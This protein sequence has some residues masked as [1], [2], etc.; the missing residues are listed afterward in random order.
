MPGITIHIERLLEFYSPFRVLG[1][2]P[3]LNREVVVR[4][5]ERLEFV[6]DRERRRAGKRW[7]IGRVRFLVRRLDEG[8]TP[9]PIEIDNYCDHGHVYGP[10]VL[11]G[12]HRLIASIVVGKPTIKA[13]YSGRV[14]IRDYL[15]GRR[16]TPPEI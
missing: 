6:P 13:V 9:D 8:W 5:R 11:D 1:V 2:P 12:H 10:L 14:D 15:T 7:H 3:R 4:F 16:K